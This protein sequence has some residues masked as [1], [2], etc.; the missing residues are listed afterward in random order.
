MDITVADTGW[1]VRRESQ[2]AVS[3][4]VNAGGS[5]YSVSDQLTVVGGLGVGAFD[6]VV[7][8]VFNV[9][10][11][12]GGVVTAVSLVTAGLYEELPSPTTNLATTGGAGS[13]CTL[14]VT[15]QVV[16]TQD[17][18]LILDGAAGGAGDEVTVGIQSFQIAAGFNTASNWALF[19]M[20]DFNSSLLKHEQGNPFHTCR[21]TMM[22][23][24]L[25]A[26]AIGDSATCTLIPGHA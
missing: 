14:D 16:L 15:F 19:G 9:D 2:E 23:L 25:T 13:G 20:S 4:V 12:S 3:A 1:T 21:Q 22:T 6:S 24:K 7:A 17:K 26:Y 10:S 11:V 5:G 8:A 18:V